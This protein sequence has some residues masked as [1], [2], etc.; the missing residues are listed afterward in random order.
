MKF[1]S[2]TTE[3]CQDVLLLLTSRGFELV[4]AILERQFEAAE[5][6]AQQKTLQKLLA[7]SDKHVKRGGRCPMDFEVA[8]GESVPPREPELK[9]G[10]CLP[11]IDS[12]IDGLG[13]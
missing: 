11:I 8:A 3:R 9:V 1:P 12:L 13:R 2:K 6:K 10:A 7:D 4:H 5:F